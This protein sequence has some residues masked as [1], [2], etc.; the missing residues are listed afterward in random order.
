VLT[1]MV[2]RGRRMGEEVMAD[3]VVF[4]FVALGEMRPKFREEGIFVCVI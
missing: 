2:D 4:A 1:G 3:M